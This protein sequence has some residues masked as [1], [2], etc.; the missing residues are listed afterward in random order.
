MSRHKPS[1]FSPP[2]VEVS[3]ISG[4]FELEVGFHSGGG[5]YPCRMSWARTVWGA[6]REARKLIRWYKRYVER[7][8][9]EKGIKDSVNKREPSRDE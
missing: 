8:L 1:V 7:R 5:W 6:K 4:G 9:K 3:A 2:E